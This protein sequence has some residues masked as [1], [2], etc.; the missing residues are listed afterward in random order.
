MLGHDALQLPSFTLEYL[1]LAPLDAY[2]PSLVEVGRLLESTPK[3][4]EQLTEGGG[5]IQ[6]E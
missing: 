6:I 2:L 3:L 4:G 1:P 5:A